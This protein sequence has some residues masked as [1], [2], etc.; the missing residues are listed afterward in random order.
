MPTN[1]EISEVATGLEK[2]SFHSNPK[3]IECQ[4][5]S[6]Y[7]TVALISHTSKF[8]SVAQSCPTLCHPM[9]C[10]M[11]GLPVH[12]QLLEFTQTHVHWVGDAIQS[13]YPLWSPSLPAL[14]LS[15]HR[16]LLQW[17][18]SFFFSPI[19]FIVFCVRWPKYWSFSIS[20]SKEYSGLIS[21]RIDWLGQLSLAMARFLT[22]RNHEIIMCSFN[23]LSCGNLLYNNR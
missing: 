17:V 1:L 19:F 21:F 23:V 9:D 18:D 7:H 20:P 15:Q 2:F 14:N 5:M 16:F 8:S 10:S 22:Y 6:N 11:P 3:E 13:S 4:R 12:H